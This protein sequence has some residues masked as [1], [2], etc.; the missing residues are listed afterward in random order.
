[1]QKILI[2]G[3]SGF[4]GGFLVEEALTK[5]LEVYAAVR[6][7]SNL[8]YLT[9]RRIQ[10]VYIDF[11][12]RES[13]RQ[14][15]MEYKFDYIVHNAGVTKTPVKE[16]YFTVNATYLENMIETLIESN[17]VPRKFT[18]ISSLAAYGPAEY[19]KSGLVTENSEPHPVTD[20]GRSKLQAERYLKSKS[21]INYTI[22]RPTAV[23]GPREKDLFTVYDLIN[24]GIE[25]TVGLTDQQLTFIYVRD[26]VSIIIG[27]TLDS[28]KNVAYFATDLEIYSSTLYNKLIR[29]SLGRKRSL[30]IRLPI[31]LVKT[32]GYIAEKAGKLTGNYPAI[33]IE[34]VNELEAKSWNCDTSNLVN[35][36]NYKPKYKLQEGLKESIAWYKEHNWLK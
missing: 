13:L 2:S 32:I 16:Q 19:T 35:D 14:I 4:V 28:R 15:F 1:M 21:E 22:I 36:L 33:N 9:D 8:Q 7:S 12:D 27:S 20:Y 31:P 34:K 3:A 6:K 24:K 26:L 11:E 5:G 18:F 30:K 23:Y 29:E 25:M 17:T 10:F